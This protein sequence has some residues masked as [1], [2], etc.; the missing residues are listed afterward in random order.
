MKLQFRYVAKKGPSLVLSSDRL[1]RCSPSKPN[2]LIYTLILNLLKY[3]YSRR[4]LSFCFH[5]QNPASSL[6]RM[7]HDVTIWRGLIIMKFFI[8][9]FFPPLCH[10]LPLRPKHLPQQL[11]LEYAQFISFSECDIRS[12][13]SIQKNRSYYS[14]TYVNVRKSNICKAF[15]AYLNVVILSCITFTIPRLV[16]ISQYLLPGQSNQA[17]IKLLSF[18]SQHISPS[19]NIITVDQK[20][21]GPIQL[22]SFLFCLPLPND[23]FARKFEKQWR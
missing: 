11:V 9:K 16:Q 3:S 1:I 8:L 2:S 14:S 19:T 12:L 20:L 17:V 15:I 4:L 6:P 5:H 23:S 18:S 7:P 13:T 21:M 22:K 10:V